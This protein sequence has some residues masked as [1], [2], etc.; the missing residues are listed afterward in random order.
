MKEDVLEQV[1]DD[2]LQFKGYFTIHNVRFRPRPRPSEY[3]S[4]QDSVASDVDV[5]GYNPKVDGVDRVVVVSC[6]SYQ[7]G[8]DHDGEAGRDAG[9]AQEPEARDV[10]GIP[11][12]LGCRGGARPSAPGSRT[13]PVNRPSPTGSPSHD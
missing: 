7:N 5:V 6:K 9:R 4:Q 2:Y 3:V 10:E 13:S 12:A 1:V 11:R 8:L